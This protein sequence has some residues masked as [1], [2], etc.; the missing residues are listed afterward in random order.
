MVTYNKYNI[1]KEINF[2]CPYCMLS[3]TGNQNLH[4][5]DLLNLS[6]FSASEQEHSWLF[7]PKNI[8]EICANMCLPGLSECQY[9]S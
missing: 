5:C 2:P 8:L 6:S 7:D 3:Y 1:Q 9:L 4:M